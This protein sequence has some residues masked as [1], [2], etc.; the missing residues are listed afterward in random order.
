[1]KISNYLV[2][3]IILLSTQVN[4]ASSATERAFNYFQMIEYMQ[5]DK[6]IEAVKKNKNLVKIR[7]Q[8]NSTLLIMASFYDYKDLVETLLQNGADPNFRDNSKNTALKFASL[9][10]QPEIALL[11]LKYGADWNSLTIPQQEKLLQHQKIIGW[12]TD[13]DKKQ[14]KNVIDIPGVYSASFSVD[15]SNSKH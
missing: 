14:G 1:M 12:R 3:T 5:A 9:H 2:L 7:N 11:L 8:N 13:E 10:D 6:V 15:F 4:R